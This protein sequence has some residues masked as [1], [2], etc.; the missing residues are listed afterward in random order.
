MMKTEFDI[1][2]PDEKYINQMPE[3]V[4]T[5]GCVGLTVKEFRYVTSCFDSRSQG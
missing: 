3:R 2:R 1:V 5:Y 4:F